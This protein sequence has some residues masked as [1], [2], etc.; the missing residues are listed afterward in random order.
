[1]RLSGVCRL[2]PIVSLALAAGCTTSSSD[3]GW[4][5]TAIGTV[6]GTVPLRGPE[7]PP[8]KPG[9]AAA[10]LE[11]AKTLYNE[12]ALNEALIM[13]V[14]LSR[15]H[16]YLPGLAELRMRVLSAMNEE[17]AIE[18]AEASDRGREIMAIEAVEAGGVP[19]T[20]GM[21]RFIEGISKL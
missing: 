21:E 10:A 11:Q 18:A 8:P 5:D 1:M 12:G 6:P 7:A 16:P 4:R 15:T 20:Y 19:E 13:C 9:S 3:A 14:D 17:R 2:W